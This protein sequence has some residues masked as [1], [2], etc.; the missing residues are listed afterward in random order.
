MIRSVI[1]TIVVYAT[2]LFASSEQ[3]AKKMDYFTDYNTA[4]KYSIKKYKPI[5][6]TVVTSTCPWCKKLENQVLQRDTIDSVVKTNFTPILQNRDKDS[7]PKDK[8][9]AT[10][11]PTTFFIDPLKQTIIHQI[12]GYKSKKEFLK[13]LEIAKNIYYKGQQ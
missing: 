2:F 3:F 13:Q 12:R 5:M 11:V 10:A 6:M 4:V 8:F 1:L 9:N 7:Y